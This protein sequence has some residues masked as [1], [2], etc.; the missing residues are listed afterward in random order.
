MKYHLSI[1]TDR[2]FENEKQWEEYKMYMA[3]FHAGVN[4]K[5]LETRGETINRNHFEGEHVITVYKLYQVS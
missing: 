5:E 4:F 2:E 3:D 1:T